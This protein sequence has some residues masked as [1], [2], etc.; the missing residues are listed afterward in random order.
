MMLGE[1]ALSAPK[2]APAV[3]SAILL[4]TVLTSAAVAYALPFRQPNCNTSSHYALVQSL[5]SGARTIDRIHG[6]SCDASWWHG[7]YFA[8]KAP[9]L[10]LVAAP[11]YAGLQALGVLRPDPLAGASF[12]RAMRAL[13]RRDLWLMGLWG[14]VLPALGLLVLLRS[15]AE[16]LA[17]GS[18]IV[19]AA[20]LAFA[21][22]LLPF[23]SLFFSHVLTAFL[24]FAAFAVL[25]EAHGTA[26]RRVCAAGLLAGFA[27]VVDY[28]TV[29]LVAVLAAYAMSRGPRLKRGV[30]F[31]AG[32]AAG[33]AP[34]AIFDT[35]AFGSP[36]HLSYVGAILHPGL[37][38][39]DV[40]GANSVGF[41]GVGVPHLDRGL[42]LL[43]G[44]RGL[45]TLGPV[46]ALAP[47]GCV[48][49]WKHGRRAEAV[50]IVAVSILY[51]TFNAGYYSP[52][53]GATPGPRLLIPMLPFA[54]LA[55]APLVR[56]R[57]I[58]LL[59]LALPSVAIL[60]AAHL[61]QPLISS[62]Y[63]TADWWHWLRSGGFSS[64][65][66]SPGAHG[67]LPTIPIV[68]AAAAALGASI[69]SVRSVE[70]TDSVAALVCLLGWLT[71]YVSFP[72]LAQ[73]FAGAAAVAATLAVIMLAS[74]RGA[75]G[76]ALMFATGAA[77]MVVHHDSGLSATVG[78]GALAVVAFT[79]RAWGEGA[80]ARL[81]RENPRRCPSG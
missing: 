48:R 31:L 27:V 19:V 66:L 33:L 17:P 11:W 21:S 45:L 60:L 44:D 78:V 67:W 80:A 20:L 57:P 38:G 70:R 14:A 18:G 54:A 59:A 40:L 15:V 46:L 25:L 35:W 24:A 47:F 68:V 3:R 8:N 55:V 22:L 34:L 9:G 7:H 29:M 26:G 72:Q 56:G 63:E 41:F 1:L 77:L 51:L 62:P 79:P 76:V 61:T 74:R 43:F 6:E 12:P 71:A 23:S 36:F 5:V 37:T 50:V 32:A 30:F 69:V 49:L 58:S 4:A 39:H 28:P 16:K 2:A 52:L 75:A 10:A 13:P 64:T 42:Q 73:S 53:G 81:T 65:I